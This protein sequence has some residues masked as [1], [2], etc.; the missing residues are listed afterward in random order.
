MAQKLAGN[1]PERRSSRRNVA[2]ADGYVHSDVPVMPS[3]RR[4]GTLARR[5]RRRWGLY[6]LLLIPVVYVFIF[7]YVPMYGVTIAFKR[8]NIKAGILGSPW[9]GMYQFDRFLS[10]VKFSQIMW[11]TLSIS[12]YSLLAGFPLP[13]IL[14]IG[15]THLRS[16]GY[17]KFIQMVSYAPHFLSVVVMV[18]LLSQL[19][20]LRSG[21]INKLIMLFGGE[22]VNFMGNASY[23]R[24]VYVW[25]GVWQEAGYGAIIYISALS[26][27]DP[28][29][30]E[31]ASIDGASMWKRIWHI[32]IPGI[33]PTVTIMLILRMG[34]L[35]G[36]GFEKI[37]LMQNS[38]NLAVSEV[39]ETYVYRVGLTA[40]MPDFSFATAVG[41]FQNVISFA[42][43]MLANF[44]SRRVSD[45]GLW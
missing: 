8:Y 25:S 23:F 28:Q 6:L 29:L 37:Y 41:L 36:V 10:N 11:N 4:R 1:A 9:V 39:I 12:L 45:N 16:N 21:I 14:A 19:L 38:T 22:A 5:I 24:H 40:S 17:R 44:I 2:P 15:L 7:N 20:N 35:L 26:A 27:V 42:L 33:L 34:S 30:H 18:S 13:I 3:P 31:A 32:D 43:V